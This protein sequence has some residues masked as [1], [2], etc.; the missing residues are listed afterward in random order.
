MLRASR[1]IAAPSSRSEIASALLGLLHTR[2]APLPH[3]SA[4]AAAAAAGAPG[5]SSS[6]SRPQHRSLSASARRPATMAGPNEAA[7]RTWED[8]LN[9]LSELITFK[10][11][12]DGKGWRDAFE[13]MPVYLEVRRQRGSGG[14]GAS[15]RASERAPASPH[16][17]PPPPPSALL[18]TSPL[19]S[20][21]ITKQ[22][23]ETTTSASASRRTSSASA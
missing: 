23:N 19:T 5:D 14:G 11:R 10:T 4:V 17:P 21:D 16:A 20:P 22:H 12:A 1:R 2:D 3:R 7:A 9:E 18:L 15:E 6:L 8:V 13:N